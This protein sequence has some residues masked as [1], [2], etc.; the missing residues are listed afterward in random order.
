MC[1]WIAH[2][3]FLFLIK[4]LLCDFYHV[5]TYTDVEVGGFVKLLDSNADKRVMIF[6]NGNFHDE[7][8]QPCKLPGSV[9][10]WNIGSIPGCEV[11]T[12]ELGGSFST[13]VT[14]NGGVTSY[15]FP[16]RCDE[17]LV[18]NIEIERNPVDGCD[19]SF[20]VIHLIC[21]TDDSY[22]FG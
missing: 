21:L 13:S 5:G 19:F 2:V 14:A 20:Y 9:T 12:P 17:L 22:Q 6:F 15:Q 16:F 18:E 8:G 3:D 4:L 10:D 7:S 1:T 11:P